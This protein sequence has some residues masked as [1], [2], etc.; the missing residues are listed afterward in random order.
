MSTITGQGQTS[1]H[2]DLAPHELTPAVD[3]FLGLISISSIVPVEVFLCELADGRVVGLLELGIRNYA[4]GCDGPCPF[5]ENWYVDEEMRGQGVG[6]ALMS[7]AEE[8]SR[9]RGYRE[10]A[11]NALIEN[12]EGHRAHEAVGFVEVE[13]TVHFRKEL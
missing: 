5:V 9:A 10:L 2:P 4:E 8:W 13:R 7:A 3:A 6:R 11:S 12:V 1:L